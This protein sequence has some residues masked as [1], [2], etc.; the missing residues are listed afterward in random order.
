MVEELYTI[1][2][3]PLLRRCQSMTGDWAE[4]EDLVQETF[5]RAMA[6]LADLEGLSRPQRQAWLNKTARRLYIDR[7]RKLR[8]E[9][10]AESETL[11]QVPF[12]QDF[13]VPAVMELVGRLPQ[14]ERTLFLLRYFQGYDAAELGQC[15]GLPASTVRSRLAAARRRLK[16]WLEE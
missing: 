3:D 16:K 8:R 11:E 12:R 9:A 5:L 15:F 6:H 10:P 2:R 14:E 4:A 7:R 13:S 1:H